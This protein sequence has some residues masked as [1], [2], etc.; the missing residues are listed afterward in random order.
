M[1][2][3][4]ALYLYTCNVVYAFKELI[5]LEYYVENESHFQPNLIYFEDTGIGRPVQKKR[6]SP[7][8]SLNIWNVY[9]NVL[10]KRPRTNNAV[11]GW[12]S[13]FNSFI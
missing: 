2:C 7:I 9:E 1:L 10:M 8:F 4:L 6:R 13:A 3:A 5:K 11:E 12:H